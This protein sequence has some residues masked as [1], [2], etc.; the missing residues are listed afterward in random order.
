PFR[1]PVRD[2]GGRVGP[3]APSGSVA[4]RRRMAVGRIPRLYGGRGADGA[5]RRGGRARPGRGARRLTARNL[6]S[7]KNPR[8]VLSPPLLVSAI[9]AVPFREGYDAGGPQSLLVA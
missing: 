6:T 8:A 2:R 9:P 5:H 4:V 1:H 3:G 7:V